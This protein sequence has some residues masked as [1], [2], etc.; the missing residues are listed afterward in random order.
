MATNSNYFSIFVATVIWI[1]L[2]MLQ[3]SFLICWGFFAAPLW[4]HQ[5]SGELTDE[6]RRLFLSNTAPSLLNQFN[7]FE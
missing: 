7:C 6:G 4:Q 3:P 1:S 5:F 2:V